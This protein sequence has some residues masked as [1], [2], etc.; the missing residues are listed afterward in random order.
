M[1]SASGD[2]RLAVARRPVA[3]REQLAGEACDPA[4]FGRSSSRIGR[5]KLADDAN[6]CGSAR[7]P[8]GVDLQAAPSAL[9]GTRAGAAGG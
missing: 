6:A 7:V 3:C 9:A 8:S 5:P 1:A 4:S 2:R